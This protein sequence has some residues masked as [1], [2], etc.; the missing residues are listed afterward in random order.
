MPPTFNA[1]HMAIALR[2]RDRR[3]CWSKEQSRSRRRRRSGAAIRSRRTKRG[4]QR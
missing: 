4:V 3:C 1:A 2:G